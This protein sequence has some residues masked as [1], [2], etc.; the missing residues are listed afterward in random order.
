MQFLYFHVFIFFNYRCLVCKNAAEVRKQKLDIK[1]DGDG[2]PVDNQ[3]VGIVRRTDG[4]T[5]GMMTHFQSRHVDLLKDV[6]DN[7]KIQDCKK[8]ENKSKRKAI[9]D[10]VIEGVKLKQSKLTVNKNKDMALDIKPDPKFQKEWD[11]E[12]TKFVNSTNVSYSLV[13]GE[14][15]HNLI[16]FLLK[17]ARYS[18]VP[19][20][21]LKGRKQITRD[22]NNNA[23]E[24]HDKMFHILD[25]F[26]DKIVSIGFTS[27]VWSNR[28]MESFV[29]LTIQFLTDE[30]E[31][32]RLVP[33]TSHFPQRHT[34]VNIKM[35]IEKMLEALG[36]D[37]NTITKYVCHD[38]AANCV[39]GFSLIDDMVQVFCICHTIQ[40][41][42]R[43]AL[44]EDV[45]GVS[46]S[47]LIKTSHELAKKV[48]MS[49]TMT[50]ELKEACKAV[51]IKYTKLL[52]AQVTRWFS[53]EMNIASLLRVQG[54]V[55]YQ[56]GGVTWKFQIKVGGFSEQFTL[57]FNQSSSYP[58]VLKQ[59]PLQQAI[60]LSQSFTS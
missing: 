39:L 54:G 34:G 33:Y 38:N 55:N 6:A 60:L 29:S 2:A 4:N 31:I 37:S 23:K 22:N 46:L 50:Q 41:C 59:K 24:G 32:I 57:C 5:R 10:A 12:L 44:K 18:R 42:V 20:L 56:N 47:K 30:M 16:S 1:L 13:G 8:E 9:D 53:T 3:S 19:P 58:N 52:P 7:K 48:K 40:L 25:H 11:R 35:K 28:D 15:F 49:G 45:M 14:P 26:K 21:K 17:K 36:L 43:D 27:D 51:G